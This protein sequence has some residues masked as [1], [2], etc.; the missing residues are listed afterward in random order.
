MKIGGREASQANGYLLLCEAIKNRQHRANLE[1][2]RVLPA[3]TAYEGG[4]SYSKRRR[5]PA[6]GADRTA[7]EIPLAYR[8]ISSWVLF[9]W[10]FSWL[11]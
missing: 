8:V 2:G 9:S 11:P 10:P 6:L 7:I 1:N 3:D 5:L 4:R